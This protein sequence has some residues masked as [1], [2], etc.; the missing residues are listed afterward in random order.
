M[1]LPMYLLSLYNQVFLET[2]SDLQKIC[3]NSRDFQTQFCFLLIPNFSILVII[4]KSI[5]IY[6]Y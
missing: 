5:L 1:D 6:S 2:V 4:D 3:E